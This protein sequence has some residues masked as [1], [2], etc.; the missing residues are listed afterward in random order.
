MAL[1]Q[2]GSSKRACTEVNQA[3][4]C[5]VDGCAADLSDCRKYYQRH[6]VCEVHSKSPQV[7]ING[8][9]LRFCQQCSRFHSLEEFNE[10]KR[11]CRKRLDGHNRRRRKPRPYLFS[12]HNGADMVQSDPAGPPMHVH[13]TTGF[14]NP[15]WSGV[16]EAPA[17][18]T[19]SDHAPSLLSS[20]FSPPQASCST[21]SHVVHPPPDS[22]SVSITASAL[23][24]GL[25]YGG[26]EDDCDMGW[27]GMTNMDPHY[28]HQYP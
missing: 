12:P 10:G 16:V 3:V 20:L 9:S 6:K 2:S 14:M 25:G 7:L 15:Q 28:Y 8:Q 17:W 5:L 13:P 27:D 4:T 11:S 1:S 22:G 19:H 23:D 24:Q 26:L 18:V 21:L